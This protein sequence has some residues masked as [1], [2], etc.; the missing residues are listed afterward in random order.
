MWRSVEW[1]DDI[2]ENFYYLCKKLIIM[3]KDNSYTVREESMRVSEPAVAYE[4]EP[5]K[6]E[7]VASLPRDLMAQLIRQGIEECKAGKGIPH[8]QIGE[9]IKARLGWI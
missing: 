9:R 2:S 7:F 1:G 8:D 6:D 5:A 3:Q 4:V